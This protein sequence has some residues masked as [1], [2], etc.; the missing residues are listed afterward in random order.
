MKYLQP[1]HIEN[2]KQKVKKAISYGQAIIFS[3]PET[4][5]SMGETLT[6]S[7]L[8]IKAFPVRFAPFNRSTTQKVAWSQDVDVIM[9]IS[10]LDIEERSLELDDLLSYKTIN[11]LGKDYEVYKIEPYGSMGN[12]FLYY[13]IGGR[14]F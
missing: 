1:K 6:E 2:A 3:K 11:V 14:K 4:S 5:D 12:D 9:Y 13:R 7:T 8:S 10:K